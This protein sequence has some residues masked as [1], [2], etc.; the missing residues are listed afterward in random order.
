MAGHRRVG[1]VLRPGA[2]ILDLG[3]GTGAVTGEALARGGRV[4]AIDA[5]PAMIARLRRDYPRAEAAIMDAHELDFPDASFDV[6]VASFVI[7]LLDDPDAAARE[8]RRVLVRGGLFAL[9]VPGEPPGSEPP[10]PQ[11]PSLWTEF[12]QYLAPGGGMGRPLDASALLSGAGFA[13]AAAQP[14]EV[15]LPM[16][17]GG[18]MLWRWH[19]SHGTVAFIDDLPPDRREE[20]RRRLVASTDADGTRTLRTIA[21]LWSARTTY[22]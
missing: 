3:A 9:T 17:G 21:T 10:E 5:A 15:N 12:S 13:G 20:F 11:I 14:I 8:V 2:R 18:D 7:H 16:S 6:V 4:T 1:R 19:L 22:A